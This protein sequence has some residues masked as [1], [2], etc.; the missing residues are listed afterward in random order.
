MKILSVRLQDQIFHFLDIRLQ[1][2]YIASE[3]FHVFEVEGA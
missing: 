3:V 2:D 1:L